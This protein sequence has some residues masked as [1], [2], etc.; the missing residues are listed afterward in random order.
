MPM[1]LLP[2]R[3][4]PRLK[5]GLRLGERT[6]LEL[7][8]LLMAAA[9][10]V[11]P[12]MDAIAKVLSATLSPGEVG[13][14][15]FLLQT[16]TL[17][18]VLVVRRGLKWPG[19]DFPYLAVSGVFLAGAILCLFWALK[20]M[21]IA[22]AIAIFFVEPL[23]LTVF[24]AVFLR[25][26]VGW[27]RV[28]AV[29]VGLLGALI[30]IRP[31][32]QAFGAVAVLPLITAVLFAAYLTTTRHLGARHSGLVMQFW[33][34]LFAALTLGI[35]LG[36]GEAQGIEVL[37]FAMP[38]G[39]EWGLLLALGVLSTAGHLTI[40][41]AFRRAPASVLAPFQYLE[42]INATLLG[43]LIFGDFPDLL[44]WTGA[45]IIVGS[46]LYVFS[47]ERRLAKL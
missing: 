12:G 8:M 43:W 7:G 40:A 27:R 37:S 31:N 3:V 19:R 35:G 22:N 14:V 38:T 46:G 9:M 29:C 23:V 1:P 10:L 24:S 4:G 6:D 25:E 13:F 34:G 32:W 20:H 28:L 2:L 33:A 26:T 39:W 41:V 30:V 21:P 47:R 15:R 18:A 36:V 45:A 11:V 16:V 17:G 42:I 44:T 5:T